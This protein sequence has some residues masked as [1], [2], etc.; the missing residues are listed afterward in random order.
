MPNFSTSCV[1]A[2]VRLKLRKF[3]C[4]IFLYSSIQWF[5][6]YKNSDLMFQPNIFTH[7]F[8]A[9]QRCSCSMWFLFI[10]FL[11]CPILYCQ[12]PISSGCSQITYLRPLWFPWD[13]S[14]PLAFVFFCY[15]TS[16][17]VFLIYWV[18]TS[19]PVFISVTWTCWQ[20][21]LLICLCICLAY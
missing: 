11:I 10:F 16:Y 4:P 9:Y 5:L 20:V 17:D 18:I 2:F 1:F 12:L 21:M 15:S 3:Q 7:P 8:I 14:L 6:T 13:E 19:K